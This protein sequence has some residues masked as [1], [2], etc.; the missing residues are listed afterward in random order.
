MASLTPNVNPT[1]SQNMPLVP[2]GHPTTLIPGSGMLGNHAA[3]VT[4]ATSD[5][6]SAAAKTLTTSLKSGAN[7]L[8]D[9]TL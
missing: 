5:S 4:N 3:N 6:T 1:A 7:H 8:A 2:V 9:R